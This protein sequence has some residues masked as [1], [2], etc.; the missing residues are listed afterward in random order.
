VSADAG[1]VARER[2]GICFVAPSAWPILAGDRN[3]P[4]IGGAEVQQ[5]LL[6]RG[7]AERGHRVSMVCMDFGQ[8][9]VTSVDGI[10]VYRMHGLHDGLPVLRFI[11]PRW[12]SLWRAMRRADADV[13]YQ[14]G[15]GALTGQVVGFTRLAGRAS[16]FAG[17]SDADFEPGLRFIAYARDRALFRWGLRRASAIVVQNATQTAAC[18]ATFGRTSTQITSCTRVGPPS[19]DHSG[20][21]LWVGS[22]RRHK[23]PLDVIAL[24]Q[25]CPG[26]RF[27]VIGDGDA[28]LMA[29]LRS[30]AERLPN[31]EVVGFVPFVD[32]EAR[33][34]GAF[35]LV[36]TSPIE[37]FP[38]TFLQAWSRGIPTASY[39]GPGVRQDGRPVGVTVGSVAELAA[40][41]LHWRTA[42]DE[43][44]NAGSDARRYAS[45][46]F[47]VEHAVT[48]YE[49]VIRQI[50][51][52]MLARQSG[53]IRPLPANGV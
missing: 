45:D 32:V 38:N 29:A 16:L 41:L 44:R 9:A 2:G 33:F 28:G 6:A 19:A 22:V 15:C 17:A 10:T 24:A 37:G 42:S 3:L 23:G 18:E 48:R 7:F 4:V 43:W 11:H 36:N 26:L 40:T 53:G 5:V 34:D 47:S 46:N 31:L 51:P 20:V 30:A 49:S 35:A 14:R 13:Y 21:V 39:A 25:A 27:R 52:D 1:A 8:P 50:A 12:T